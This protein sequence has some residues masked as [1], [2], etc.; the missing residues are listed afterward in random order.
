MNNGI[1]NIVP[2]L[3]YFTRHSSYERSTHAS[4]THQHW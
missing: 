1:L 2:T 4:D 3:N